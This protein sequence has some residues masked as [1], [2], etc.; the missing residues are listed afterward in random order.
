MSMFPKK[1]EYP[2]NF[3]KKK[4]K[5]LLASLN[6]QETQFAFSVKIATVL[7]NTASRRRSPDNWLKVLVCAWPPVPLPL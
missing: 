1:V 5:S 7:H 3:P 2:F 4:K 6:V